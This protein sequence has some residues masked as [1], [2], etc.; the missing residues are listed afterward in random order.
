MHSH[1]QMDQHTFGWMDDGG[2]R[3]SEGEKDFKLEN[4]ATV[5]FWILSVKL[6]K[7]SNYQ[8]SVPTF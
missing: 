3:E 8:M 4:T 7:K 1:G 2:M 6:G 5:Y